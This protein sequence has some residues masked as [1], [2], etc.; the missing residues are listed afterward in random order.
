MDQKRPYS[1]RWTQK[2]K[3]SNDKAWYKHF[4]D[5]FSSRSYSSFST[6]DEMSSRRKMQIYYDLY[7]NIINVDDF[8]YICKPYGKDVGELPAKFTNKDIS[9][10]NIK[11][12]LG[13]EMKRPFSYRLLA[14]N[15][16]ATT[17]KE[18]EQFDRIKEWTTSQVMA[19]VMMNLQKQT[20]EQSQGRELSMEQ[21]QQLEQQIAQETERM[22]PEE[23]KRYMSREHQ[24]PAEVQ[25]NQLLAY[26]VEKLNIRDKF[27]KI[28]KHGC[29][30][31]HLLALSTIVNGEPYVGVVNP[32]N[33]DYDNSSD[34][35]YIEDSEWA[36]CR[37]YMTPSRIVEFF[38]DSPEG[39]TDTE[40]D[41][42][43]KLNMD[44]SGTGSIPDAEFRFDGTANNTGTIPVVH[45]TFKSLRKVGF[46]K[47]IDEEGNLREQLV[48]ESYKA[49]ETIGDV[50]LEWEWIPEAHEVYNIG[51]KFYKKAR[52]VPGQFKDLN[53]LYHCKLPYYGAVIDDMNSEVTSPM[54]RMLEWQYL[55]NIC[56][57]RIEQL[58][59]SDKGKQVFMNMNML[60]ISQGV[61]I[62]QFFY[63]LDAMK[64]GFLNPNEEGNRGGN[65]DI[66]NAVKEVDLGMVADIQKYIMVAEY[67]EKRCGLANGITDAMRGMAAAN[68]A[69]TNNQMNQVQSSYI[70]EP[71]FEIQNQVKR[72]ILMSVIEN[73]KVAYAGRE[74]SEKLAYVLDDLSQQMLTIDLGLLD[75]TTFG[76]FVANSGKAWEAKQTV[77]QLSFAAMQNN[78][79]ELSDII[80]VIRSESVQEAE[81]LLEVAEQ[82]AQEREVEMSKQQAEQ[83]RQALEQQELYAQQDHERQKELIILKEEERR[84][85]EIQKQTILSLGFNENKDLDNNGV[86][87]V[88]EVAKFGVDAQIKQRKQDL[89]EEKFAH[90]IKQDETKNKLEKEKLAATKAKSAVGKKVN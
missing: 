55:Y 30:S 81:E 5:L 34:V 69:V 61:D 80:K 10:G 59:A 15:E 27:N 6:F 31:G 70:I 14:V 37:Y 41:D 12:M 76:L 13:M 18:K 43:Y 52:P 38:S 50:S 45:C 60:P 39:L 71:Y 88:L 86:P 21:Q 48:D 90:Q 47:Y 49:D 89:D 66:V 35:D 11:V 83:Q 62:M 53:N 75:S 63:Y 65:S 8:N 28:F 67:I 82:K 72:N 51:N 29:I 36:V 26:F 87:D 77:Q 68:E 25:G 73:S 84:K 46:L 3:Y 33:F 1:H 40:I 79:A 19:P 7:N 16:E 64:T 22:T 85:T 2:E 4:A 57:F 9:S 78:K 56:I 42:I 20:L 54:A 23:V 74:N 17:R 58:M 44:F 32:M 24:D